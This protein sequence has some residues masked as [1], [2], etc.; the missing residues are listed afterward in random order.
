MYGDFSLR[1]AGKS[2]TRDGISRYTFSAGFIQ[3]VR[4]IQKIFLTAGACFGFTGIALGAF[5]AHALK[6]SFSSEMLA[7][8]DTAVRYQM[9]HALALLAVGLMH[10]FSHHR[11][12]RFAGW[13]F[14]GGVLL[15]SGSLYAMALSGIRWLGII[16]P[17]GGISF[18][19]GWIFL[20]LSV[21]KIKTEN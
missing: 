17:F 7:V 1:A 18:L 21:V 20:F 5:G 9:Y 16:T 4:N 11:F 10:Q 13:C 12:L 8:F 19:A 14:I 3:I 2:P 15:F 6:S